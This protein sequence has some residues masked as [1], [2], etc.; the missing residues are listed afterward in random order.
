M[1][2]ELGLKVVAADLDPQA[3]LTA[4]FLNE[5]RLEELWPAGKHPLT[6]QGVVE[7][8]LRGVGDIRTPHTERITN[9]VYLIPGDLGLSGFEDKL[10]DAW[11][12]CHNRDEAAFRITTAFYRAAVFAA[13][14]VDA[15]VVLIDVAPNLGA[16]NRA[17]LIASKY[18]VIPLA[19]DLFS[20]QGLRNL[21]PQLRSWRQSWQELKT[22]NPDPELLLPGGEMKPAGYIVLQHAIRADR[23]VKAYLRWMEKIPG[24]YQESVLFEPPAQKTDVESDPHCLATLKHY[25]SLMSLAME[26]HKPMFFLKPADGAIGAHV[27]AVKDC[28][29]DFRYLAMQ[30]AEKCSVSLP[31]KSL[32]SF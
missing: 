11:P 2:S 4:M 26:A 16:I 9:H 31:S 8:M 13:N 30:I 29:R 24:E 25:R 18:V 10:S 15:D 5:E 28:F 20:L 7:P 23:P 22:K 19:S 32:I 21:G 6:I 17:A 14:T 27:E 1:F 3:N 12:R